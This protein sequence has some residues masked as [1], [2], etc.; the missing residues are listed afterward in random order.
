MAFKVVSGEWSKEPARH[1][2]TQEQLPALQ[3]EQPRAFDTNEGQE[4]LGNY[5][6]RNL[7][8]VPALGYELA[9]SGLGVGNIAELAARKAH[10]P[11]SIQTALS[12]LLPT[13]GG[14]REEIS[15]VLPSYMTESRPGDF[16][17][18]FALTEVPIIAAQIA[19]GV[20]IPAALARSGAV[21]GGGY[22]GREMGG[23][24]GEALGDREIGEMIGG[25]GGGIA[26]GALTQTRRPSKEISP[27]IQALEESAFEEGKLGRLAD[28]EKE[29]KP[30]MEALR[31]QA[32]SAPKMLA[33]EKT[34]FESAKKK[35]VMG[36]RKEITT[37]QKKITDIDKGR[38]TFYKAA[39][40]L[41]KRAKAVPQK[42]IK[43]LSKIEKDLEKGLT[44][45]DKSSLQHNIDTLKKR[46]GM[47]KT[48]KNLTISDAKKFQKNFNDQ[49]YNRDASRSF[50]REMGNITNA[51]NDFIEEVGSEEHTVN[52]Q[53]GET[54][55]RKLKELQRNKKEFVNERKQEMAD[56]RREKFS[57]EKE[58]FSKQSQ[59][60]A[61]E[62]L[63]S[64]E[65]EYGSAVK[66]VNKETFQ[67]FLSSQETQSRSAGILEKILEHPS[68]NK[69]GLSGIGVALGSMMGG[70]FGG[71][72]GFL[73]G[74]IA[75]I[76][77]NEY[78][79]VRN[80]LKNHPEIAA[81]Y[82]KLI[83]NAGKQSIPQ[84][85]KDV[86]MLGKRIEEALPSEGAKKSKPRKFGSFTIIKE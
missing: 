59:Q 18:E 53:R 37:Y 39:E 47:D 19:S 48:P 14:A 9:R 35:A 67:D 27:K 8:K 83:I 63:R 86:N 54:E 80:A 75:Q 22:L 60:V 50:K 32:L 79:I 52:W 1:V 66:K 78:S 38:S 71:A 51:L 74:K 15:K 28:I 4:S 30:G 43:T 6:L 13:M 3:T 68:V 24:V 76:A 69:W 62:Q 56:I 20:G 44:F 61:K 2:K 41:E 81:D 70:K 31:K 23:E 29:M 73:G 33:K 57:A 10:A 77:T 42:L 17:A 7:S 34:L 65:K 46:V 5:L 49:I 21:L 36:K 40:K 11:Q 16:P 12:Y 85:I 55:T 25:L 64:L 72:F 82:F 84:T 45:T 26:G 58:V